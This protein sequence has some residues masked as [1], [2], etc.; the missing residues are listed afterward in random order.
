MPQITEINHEHT[1]ESL[2]FNYGSKT[3]ESWIRFTAVYRSKPVQFTVLAK[4]YQSKEGSFS[5]WSWYIQSDNYA[6]HYKDPNHWTG[7]G[8]DLTPTARKALAEAVS[9]DVEQRLA[10]FDYVRSTAKAIVRE[11]EKTTY[12][13]ADILE[14]LVNR[15]LDVLPVHGETVKALQAWHSTLKAAERAQNAVAVLLD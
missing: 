6:T 8:G 12:K 11:V 14:Q 15:N 10:E 9:A 5:P 7:R 3:A 4:Q 13:P 2:S 1:S